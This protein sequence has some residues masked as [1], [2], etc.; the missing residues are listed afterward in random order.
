MT[1]RPRIPTAVPET[2]PLPRAEFG[3]LL[4]EATVPETLVEETLAAGV[5]DAEVLVTE[6]TTTAEVPLVEADVIVNVTLLLAFAVLVL[7]DTVPCAERVVA[8]PLASVYE[9]LRRSPCPPSSS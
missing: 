4:G 8:F 5:V 6:T 9:P 3:V 2:H 7:G 1:T